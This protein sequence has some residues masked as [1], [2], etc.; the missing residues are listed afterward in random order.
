MGAKELREKSGIVAKD[1]IWNSKSLARDPRMRN[2]LE[3][4]TLS[5]DRSKIFARLATLTP[6]SMARR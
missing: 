5:N 1:M 6:A 3:G 4:L 2:D